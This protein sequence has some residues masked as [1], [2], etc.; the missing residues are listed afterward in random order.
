MKPLIN[1]ESIWWSERKEGLKRIGEVDP[2]PN[3]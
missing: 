2:G 3:I 1:K